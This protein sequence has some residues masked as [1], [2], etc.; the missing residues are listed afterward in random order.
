MRVAKTRAL[1]SFAVTTKLS[2]S[3]FLH[4]QKASFLT[5]RLIIIICDSIFYIKMENLQV[6]VEP[7]SNQH[8]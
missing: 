1:I 8:Y 2:A 6:H 4:M 5:T 7:T 3:L